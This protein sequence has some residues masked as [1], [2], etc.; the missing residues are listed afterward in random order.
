MSTLET[1]SKQPSSPP[2]QLTNGNG[3]L[4][5]VR[6]S[7]LSHGRRSSAF[8]G[9]M[10]L[11]I[12]VTVAALAAYTYWVGKAQVEQDANRVIARVWKYVPS[13]AEPPTESKTIETTPAT[14]WDGLATAAQ[15]GRQGHRAL[16][17]YGPASG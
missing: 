5:P 12:A 16:C 15:T 17:A 10:I 8:R 13:K 6:S 2:G 14:P 9:L 3:P 1:E 4:H 11:L 7:D